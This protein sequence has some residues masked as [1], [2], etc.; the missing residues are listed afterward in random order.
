MELAFTSFCSAV[1]VLANLSSADLLWVSFLPGFSEELLFRG[2][3]IPALGG[4]WCASLPVAPL[5]LVDAP[6]RDC[7]NWLIISA[8]ACTGVIQGCQLIT[9]DS[10]AGKLYWYQALSL[11][12][13]IGRVA[14]IWL[15]P[16]GQWQWGAA[17]VQRT[18]TPMTCL[19][20]PWLTLLPMFCLLLCGSKA[21]RGNHK[22]L[23]ELSD[24]ICSSN[25]EHANNRD[26]EQPTHA[27]ER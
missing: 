26:S 18:S 13:S 16:S 6:F 14:G 2:A 5:T 4:G 7:M 15:L 9:L 1:Q 20:L 19:C 21:G 12:C 10:C 25:T 23:A 8:A 3:L 24:L 27:Q 11:E 17:M 22:Y